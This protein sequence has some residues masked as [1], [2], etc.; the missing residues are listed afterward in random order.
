MGLLVEH[1]RGRFEHK[2]ERKENCED[3]LSKSSRIQPRIFITHPKQ[4]FLH[5]RR[6]I[7][8][9]KNREGKLSSVFRGL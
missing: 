3:F 6:P 1:G 9:S 2:I 7:V 8:I 4:K 5:I